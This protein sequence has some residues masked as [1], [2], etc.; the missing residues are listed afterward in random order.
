MPI[1]LHK[2]SSTLRLSDKKKKKKVCCWSGHPTQE[3]SIML[4]EVP[5]D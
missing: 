5:Y 2:L 1:G 3:I 4:H